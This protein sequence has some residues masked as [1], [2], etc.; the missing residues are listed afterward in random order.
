MDFV[1][2]RRGG[3]PLKDQLRYQLEL[4]ILTGGLLPGQRLPSVRTLARRLELHPNT[5]A[6]AYKAL[7]AT[8]HVEVHKGSGVFVRPGSSAPP[9]GAS[10]DE[11]LRLALRQAFRSGHST[12]AIRSAL[13]RWLAA[14][15]VD[16]IVVI[17]PAREMAELLAEEVRQ[18]VGMVVSGVT[19]LD[20]E[21][22]PGLLS[23]ALALSVPYHQEAVANLSAA[24]CVEPLALEISEERKREALALPAGSTLLVVSHAPTVLPFADSYLKSLLGDAV[25]VQTRPVTAT[26]EWRALL[27]I[28]DLVVADVLAIGAVRAARS[29]RL[30]EL[31]LLSRESVEHLRGLARALGHRQPAPA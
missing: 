8:A 29:Y 21:R 28:A 14:A 30:S 27:P 19:L 1:L 9:L 18:A 22:N 12:A 11:I 10:L 25:V 31:R 26:R 24:A 13:E 6:A 2:N 7:E 3:I 23:G 16:G 17:D 20:V 4:K 15:P 5:V